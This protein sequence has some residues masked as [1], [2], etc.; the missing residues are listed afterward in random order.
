MGKIIRVLG[1]S[2]LMSFKYFC[3]YYRNKLNKAKPIN[4]ALQ[5]CFLHKNV[6]KEVLFWSLWWKYIKVQTCS[7]ILWVIVLFYFYAFWQPVLFVNFIIYLCFTFIIWFSSVMVRAYYQRASHVVKWETLWYYFL[8]NSFH[9]RRPGKARCSMLTMK[10]H[11]AYIIAL[12]KHQTLNISVP[13]E[14][15]GQETEDWL[16]PPLRAIQS[17]DH[18]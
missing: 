4:D 5:L 18:V 13:L 12:L 15:L 8:S 14:S 7:S 11:L 3:N 10:S 17:V 16:T 9:E 6:K 1:N 2:L